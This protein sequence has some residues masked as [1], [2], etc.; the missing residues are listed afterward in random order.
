VRFIIVGV[1]LLKGK[2]SIKEI[3]AILDVI[4]DYE[5]PTLKNQSPALRRQRAKKIIKL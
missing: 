1:F 3:E 4:L 2:C 5:F